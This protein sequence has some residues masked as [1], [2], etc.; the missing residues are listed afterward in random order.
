MALGASRFSVLKL[1]LGQG[2]ILTTVGI[3]LGV[4]GAYFFGQLLSSFL[5]E[6]SVTDVSS[7]LIVA[8]LFIAAALLA[9]LGPARRATGIDPLTA[10]RAE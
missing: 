5:F 6:T 8:A 2:L 1:V 3:A 10:L 9:A 4:A 7:H